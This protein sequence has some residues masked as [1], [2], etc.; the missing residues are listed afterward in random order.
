MRGERGFF[1]HVLLKSHC[2]LLQQFCPTWRKDPVVNLEIAS[3][4]DVTLHLLGRGPPSG[5]RRPLA[6]SLRC[7]DFGLTPRS[8]DP[9]QEA[10]REC[11][12]HA[13]VTGT[14]HQ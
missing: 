6:L 10:A 3:H 14:L 9:A 11:V 5:S 4:F 2:T 13:L 12:E 8:H 1:L 7:A